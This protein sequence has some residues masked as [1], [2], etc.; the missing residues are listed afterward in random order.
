MEQGLAQSK[1]KEKSFSLHTTSRPW[2]Y[3]LINPS[4]CGVH[5]THILSSL[6]HA[7]FSQSDTTQSFSTIRASHGIGP[8]EISAGESSVT[9]R[10][11]SLPSGLLLLSSPQVWPH[12]AANQPLEMLRLQD[13][14]PLTWPPDCHL[15]FSPPLLPAPAEPAGS[16][17]PNLQSIPLPKLWSN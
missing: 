1:K 11:A 12:L 7:C 2:F 5:D 17:D 16:P 6:P 14:K 13:F 8:R 15:K 3:S 4:K 9:S 10:S